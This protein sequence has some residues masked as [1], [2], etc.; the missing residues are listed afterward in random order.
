VNDVKG[1]C[2][3]RLWAEEVLSSTFTE[4]ESY[5][6]HLCPNARRSFIFTILAV[7]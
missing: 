5:D 7:L 2:D 6:G 3:R 1:M 4:C